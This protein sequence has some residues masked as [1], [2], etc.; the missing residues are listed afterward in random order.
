MIKQRD[1]DVLFKEAN[2]GA[3]DEIVMTNYIYLEQYDIIFSKEDR[4]ANY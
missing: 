1:S 3:C 4:Q 2:L